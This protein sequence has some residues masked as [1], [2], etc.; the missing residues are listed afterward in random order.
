MGHGQRH[1]AMR[2]GGRSG[3]VAWPAAAQ[4]QHAIGAEIGEGG[5]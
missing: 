4:P 1:A 3:S 2:C 5:G